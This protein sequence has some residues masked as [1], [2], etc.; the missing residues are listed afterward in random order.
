MEYNSK[1]PIRNIYYMLSYAYQTLSFS[2]YKNF[3]TEAFDNIQDLYAEILLIGLPFIIRGGLV[4]DYIRTE[5]RSTVIRGK[6]EINASIKRNALVDKKLVV[7]YDEFSE[8]V[9]L[10]QI[11]KSTL[12]FF[13]HSSK[14]AKEKRKKFYSYLP[15]FSNVSDVE[16]NL[17]L[18]KKVTYNR[19]NIRYQ[20][21]IDICR[22]LYEELLISDGLLAKYQSLQDEQRLSS[23]YEKF[24]F[25][26]YQRE[27]NYK[28][29]HPQ[30]P[31]KVDNGYTE[32]LPVMQTDIVLQFENQTLIVDTKF[33]SENMAIRFSG[34]TA[35]QKSAN[36]YQIFTYINN[37]KSQ[38]SEQVG[39]MLLYAMTTSREQPNHHYEINGKGIS[40]VALDLNKDFE[41]IRHQLLK[42]TSEY[43]GQNETLN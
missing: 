30:I 11:I 4:K 29:I 27:T 16:L 6:V 37:W 15:Y 22:F 10:N 31:W 40:V 42:F 23:L 5:E 41:I 8:D 19:Q 32:A 24:V 43:F 36:L 12:V 28:V 2:E 9:L 39:G 21:L 34:G 14:L 18:W 1:I 13:I 3:D 35:K 26:F 38:D 17:S 33:Y 20:F 25:A 7:I